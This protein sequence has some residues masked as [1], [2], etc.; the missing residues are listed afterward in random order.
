MNSYISIESINWRPQLTKLQV[1]SVCMPV[2]SPYIGDWMGSIYS[3]GGKRIDYRLFLNP[4][5]SY[6]RLTRQ[7]STADRID[8]GRWH[9]RE[10]EEVLR[11]EFESP[12]E[13]ARIS[14]HWS[15]LS[16]K[17][18]EDSNCLMVLRWVGLASR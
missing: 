9:H 8:Q 7:E 17:T 10:G 12:D 13:F 1:G 3:T 4:D 15:V 18:C 5:G 2:D 6:E 14:D 16:V 11:L